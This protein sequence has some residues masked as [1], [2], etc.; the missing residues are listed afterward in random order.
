MGKL[1]KGNKMKVKE[2][3]ELLSKY[4]GE[5]ELKMEQNGG[6]YE[7]DLSCVKVEERGEELWLLD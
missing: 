7:S 6:E 4:D 1:R 3:I 2:L 5:L